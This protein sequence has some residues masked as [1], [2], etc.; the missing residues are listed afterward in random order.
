MYFPP[1]KTLLHSGLRVRPIDLHGPSAT[2][3]MRAGVAQMNLIDPWIHPSNEYLKKK[4]KPTGL[5]GTQVGTVG[6][7]VLRQRRTIRN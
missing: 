7:R 5:G 6:M 3:V 1:L 2:M 4:T